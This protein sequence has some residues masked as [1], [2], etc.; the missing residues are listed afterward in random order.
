MSA[1]EEE[2]R[3]SQ[4]NQNPSSDEASEEFDENFFLLTQVFR[5]RRKKPPDTPPLRQAIGE[6]VEPQDTASAENEKKRERKK[7]GAGN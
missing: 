4:K 6:R 3:F 1:K 2:K 5:S 7:N